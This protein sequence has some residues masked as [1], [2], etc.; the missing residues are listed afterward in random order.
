MYRHYANSDHKGT[1]AVVAYADYT[2][3][4]TNQYFDFVKV[5]ARYDAMGDYA[6]STKSVATTS[7]YERQRLT[8]GSTLVYKKTKWLE[9]DLRVNFEKYFY[10]SRATYSAASGDKLTVELAFIF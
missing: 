5:N 8:V 10:P 2:I 9:A 3:P 6:A 4:V 1:H 7:Q